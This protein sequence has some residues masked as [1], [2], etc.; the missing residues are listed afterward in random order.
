[1]LRFSLFCVAFFRFCVSICFLLFD[2]LLLLWLFHLLFRFLDSLLFG[3]N[4]RDSLSG[5][6]SL[7]IERPLRFLATR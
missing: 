5:L 6:L 2:L 4:I 3:K 7:R 1:M